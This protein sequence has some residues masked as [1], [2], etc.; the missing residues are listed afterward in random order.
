VGKVV[1]AKEQ[2]NTKK[3]SKTAAKNDATAGN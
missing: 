1:H 3:G 2:E